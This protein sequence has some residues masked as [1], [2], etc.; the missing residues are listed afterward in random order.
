MYRA[1]HVLTLAGL[2]AG[3]QRK[4]YR[5]R[6]L[7]PAGGVVGDDVERDDRPA[8]FRPNQSQQACLSEIG[9][10]VAGEVVVWP[11]LAVTGQRAVDDPRVDRRNLGIV[12]PQALLDVG[13]E[14]LE[15]NVGITDQPVEDL[16][17]LVALE[18][19]PDAPLI[20]ISGCANGCSRRLVVPVV[21]LPAQGL[22]LRPSRMPSMRTR[23][24]SFVPGS[25]RM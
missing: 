3:E 15:D 23:T 19:E 4:Q 7:E 14:L 13:A 20:A 2:L 21:I 17:S 5:Q 12:D 6:H 10:V 8:F 1:V 24:R 18:V 9:Q 25:V 22:G 11:S 16:A